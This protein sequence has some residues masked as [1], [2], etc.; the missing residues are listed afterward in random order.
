MSTATDG[1]LVRASS[2]PAMGGTNVLP[3]VLF[4]K[5]CMSYASSPFIS[6][7]EKVKCARV[8][9]MA[10]NR[11]FFGTVFGIEDNAET[12]TYIGSPN[13]SVEDTINII[14][15]FS[16]LNTSTATVAK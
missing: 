12:M 11:S 3:E 7:K 2:N 4:S 9:T 13:D 15:A 16:T 14:K 1:F 6:D 10:K 5:V 8:F